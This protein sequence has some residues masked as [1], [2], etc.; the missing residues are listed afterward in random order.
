MFDKYIVVTFDQLSKLIS[1]ILFISMS[2]RFPTWPIWFSCRAIFCFSKANFLIF[3]LSSISICFN[4]WS[5]CLFFREWILVHPS[6]LPVHPF[7]LLVHPLR[8]FV[9]P[10]QIRPNEMIVQGRYSLK[11]TP[12]HWNLEMAPGLVLT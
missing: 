6:T 11:I 12:K 7:R 2:N 4:A 1:S 5:S 10:P 3:T 8:L 9:H